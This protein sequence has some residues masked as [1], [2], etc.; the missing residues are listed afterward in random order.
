MKIAIALVL[1]G[2]AIQPAAEEAAAI[3]AYQAD[4]DSAGRQLWGRPLCAPIVIV[5][6]ATGAFHSSEPAPGA[7]PPLRANTAFQWGARP[8]I[9]VLA[10]LPRDE[11]ALR[12]LLFHEAWHVHQAEL[13][14]P[15]NDAVAGHL[16]DWRGRYL[17]R[18]EWNALRAALTASGAA[19]NGHVRAALAFRAQRLAAFPGAADMERAQMRHEGLAAYTGAALSGAPSARALVALDS[20]P[21]R[22]GLARSFAY[23]STPAWGLLLD[24]LRP[25]W[26]A[27]LAGGTDLP[28]L[29]PLAP[30]RRPN[31]G[32]YG[33]T[34]LRLAEQREGLAREARLLAALLATAEQSALR[35]PLTNIQL[36]YDPDQVSTAPDGSRLYARITLRDRWGSI[37]VGAPGLRITSDYQTAYAPWPLP[38]DALSLASG[39][40]VVERAGGGV[41]LRRSDEVAPA[42]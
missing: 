7:L 5:D 34:A 21:A 42:R 22:P 31:A 16:D 15:A 17:I 13:G 2:Q 33:G 30:A 8:W 23:A 29:V 35:L 39:W 19:R 20:G 37:T 38:A 3:S 1:A 12:E 6:T 14:L 4:C 25:G 9:M 18:L 28:D 41:E 11:A 36:D 26:R 40:R 32:R 10:P 27:A 24:A